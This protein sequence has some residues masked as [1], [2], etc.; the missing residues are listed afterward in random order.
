VRFRNVRYDRGR[1]ERALE[2]A[3]LAVELLRAGPVRHATLE[4]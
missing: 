3:G 2:A 1:V 4:A